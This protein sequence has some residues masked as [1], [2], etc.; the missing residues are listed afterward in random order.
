[1]AILVGDDNYL[2]GSPLHG[3]GAI[4]ITTDAA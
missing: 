1:M 4:H 3:H 2:I